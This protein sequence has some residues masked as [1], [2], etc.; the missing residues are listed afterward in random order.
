M[1]RSC[2]LLSRLSRSVS[3]SL[4]G[5]GNLEEPPP[6][7]PPLGGAPPASVKKGRTELRGLHAFDRLGLIDCLACGLEGRESYD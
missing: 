7:S 1:S 5:L 3:P 2:T 6:G 4:S